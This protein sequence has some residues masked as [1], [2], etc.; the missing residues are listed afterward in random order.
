MEKAYLRVKRDIIELR[1]PPGHM[2][3]EKQ[4]VSAS[5]GSSKTP[6]REA[7]ARLHRDGLVTP[8]RRRGYL[9]SEVTFSGV[10]DL[11]DMHTLLQ[12][13]AAGR[14][15]AYGLPADVLA[16]LRDLG[17]DEWSGSL[18]GPRS[19]EQL[20]RA[21]EFEAIIAGGARNRR[22]AGTAVRVLDEIER[23]LRMTVPLAL[24][25]LD[26]LHTCRAIV[27]AIET[28]DAERSRA[29]M[30]SRCEAAARGMLAALALRPAVRAGTPAPGG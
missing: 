19:A 26:R 5:G 2:I 18:D 17:S 23:V 4:V 28:G 12:G 22:L 6:I 15:A 30:R 10:V 25:G 8:V 11:C 20:R 1:L 27:E 3:S 29:A 16:R 9:V 7:L 13:E 14:T 24:T 21:V